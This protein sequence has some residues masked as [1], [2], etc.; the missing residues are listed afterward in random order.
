M[1]STYISN[2][3][4]KKQTTDGRGGSSWIPRTIV[5]DQKNVKGFVLKKD[6]MNLKAGRKFAPWKD[7]DNFT[8]LEKYINYIPGSH[9]VCVDVP[10][11]SNIIHLSILNANEDVFERC[12]FTIYLCNVHQI[13]AMYR[14]WR[15]D[16]PPDAV[17]SKVVKR[18]KLLNKV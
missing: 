9:Y 1:S 3:F 6:F 12:E 15:T 5:W 17:D 2:P 16:R 8:G 10:E 14:K 13:S 11:I 18:K 7:V 4:R